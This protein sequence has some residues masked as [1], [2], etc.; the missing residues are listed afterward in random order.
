MKKIQVQPLLCFLSNPIIK[1]VMY[2]SKILKEL[3]KNKNLNPDA[4][5]HVTIN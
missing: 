3:I 1:C 2:K 5:R 4:S